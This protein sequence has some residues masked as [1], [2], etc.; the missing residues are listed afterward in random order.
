[1]QEKLPAANRVLYGVSPACAR[2]YIVPVQPHCHAS[3]FHHSALGYLSPVE[4]ERHARAMPS[5]PGTV[6]SVGVLAAVKDKPLR[7]GPGGS[8]TA[9]ARAGLRRAWAGTK[10][11]APVE[12]NKGTSQPRRTTPRHI[13][14]FDP[15]SSTVR[16]T[17]AG[18]ETCSP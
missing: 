8:L 2:L 6:K 15:K 11:R 17:G 10:E 18:P 5:S 7:A 9:A 4:F 16:E 1:G 3:A 12:P 14:S 13:T